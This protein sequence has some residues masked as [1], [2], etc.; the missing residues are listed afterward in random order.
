MH[1][2]QRE[3][4]IGEFFGKIMTKL[5]PIMDF[6]REF[7]SMIAAMFGLDQATLQIEKAAREVEDQMQQLIETTKNSDIGK[8]IAETLKD[9]DPAKR[10]EELT[11]GVNALTVP[12]AIKQLNVE[13]IKLTS[14]ITNSADA[15]KNLGKSMGEFQ[16]VF[17]KNK[18]TLL[19]ENTF[20]ELAK[21]FEEVIQKVNTL[22]AGGQFT[23][24]EEFVKNE[25]GSRNFKTI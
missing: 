4:K 9:F 12:E 21:S 18:K 14:N 23:E 24:L 7:G 19:Q 11:T 2:V 6:F 20:D 25:V 13:Y 22:R 17:S 1:L 3:K 8:T 16:K 15:A 10:L 5:Q